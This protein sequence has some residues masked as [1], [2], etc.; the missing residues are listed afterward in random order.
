[1]KKI[2]LSIICVLFSMSVAYANN[3]IISS[4]NIYFGCDHAQ[5]VKA[6]IEKMPLVLQ[7][8]SNEQHRNE[9][10]AFN[11]ALQEAEEFW[12]KAQK[13][14]RD[15]SNEQQEKLD[16]RTAQF[17]TSKLINQLTSLPADCTSKIMNDLSQRSISWSQEMYN[18]MYKK[19]SDP[20]VF[21]E[22]NV[23]L[24]T[25]TLSCVPVTK[26]LAAVL[27][28][29]SYGAFNTYHWYRYEK[30][31]NVQEHI[32]SDALKQIR[33]LYTTSSAKQR[34]DLID[35]VLFINSKCVQVP[36]RR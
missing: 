14:L 1:M 36:Y 34:Q 20:S 6:N 30:K 31:I 4:K 8:I 18:L 26:K 7:N 5:K 2:Y 21:L 35:E 23:G 12:Q 27:S 10:K 29:L 24:I 22:S 32:A 16:S 3:F 13:K 19:D 17:F 28:L 9:L 33:L 15:L 11:A 25:T